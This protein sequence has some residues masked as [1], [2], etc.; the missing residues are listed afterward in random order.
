VVDDFDAAGYILDI[1]GGGEGVIG[2]L[3]GERVV[4]IDKQKRELEEAAPGALKIVIDDPRKEQITI[5]DM[6]QMRSGYPWEE[7]DPA[8][9]EALLSAGYLGLIDGFPLTSDPGTRFQHSNLTSHWLGVIV[10]RACNTDLR[11]FAQEHLSLRWW[12]S[13]SDPCRRSDQQAGFGCDQE[14]L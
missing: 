13:L 14:C 7:T 12:A 11:S 1:G 6:L 10:A 8:L 2:Q 4:A 5:R 9:F 3:K